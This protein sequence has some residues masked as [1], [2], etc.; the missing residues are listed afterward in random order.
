MPALSFQSPP[1]GYALLRPRAPRPVKRGAGA[2]HA[3]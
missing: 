1:E 2:K 3:N